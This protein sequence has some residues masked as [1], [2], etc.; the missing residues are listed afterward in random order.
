VS[1]ILELLEKNGERFPD[2][3]AAWRG[4][5]LFVPLLAHAIERARAA[6]SAAFE[7]VSMYDGEDTASPEA[8]RRAAARWL[9]WLREHGPAPN[10]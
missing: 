6:A 2:V 1:A 10:D 9:A 8:R 7:A 3:A 4:S 5:R